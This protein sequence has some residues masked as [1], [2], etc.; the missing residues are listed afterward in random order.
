MPG[1]WTADCPQPLGQPFGRPKACPHSHSP[2][3]HLWILPETQKSVTH[4]FGLKRHLC[5]RLHSRGSLWMPEYEYEY[6]HERGRTSFV[7]LLR[8]EALP[9]QVNLD[10]LLPR[11][12]RLQQLHLAEP[13]LHLLAQLVHLGALEDLPHERSRGSQQALA[14]AQLK[15]RRERPTVAGGTSCSTPPQSRA[16]AWPPRPGQRRAPGSRGGMRGPWRRH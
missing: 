8:R 1:L 2:N 12:L 14:P 5:S 16:K 15:S 4:V 9:N 10:A 11:A 7:A 3:N 6:E 13:L